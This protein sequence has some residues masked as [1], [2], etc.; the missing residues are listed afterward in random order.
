MKFT[1]LRSLLQTKFTRRERLVLLV[2]LGIVP[3]SFA[4]LLLKYTITATTPAAIQAALAGGIIT[5]IATVSSAIYKEASSYFQQTDSNVNAKVQMIT[6]LVQKYYNPWINSAQILGK[7]LGALSTKKALENGDVESLLYHIM[8]YYGYRMKF[9]LES[10]GLILL[11][12]V[13]EQDVVNQLYH[14]TETALDWKG[15]ATHGDASYLEWLFLTY[16]SAS[17]GPGG[18]PP[19]PGSVQPAKPDDAA[20]KPATGQS[21]PYLFYQFNK[22]IQQ[23]RGNPVKDPSLADM[24]DALTS[25]CKDHPDKVGD[26][27]KALDAFATTFQQSIEKLYTAWGQ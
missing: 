18:A 8:V 16:S 23:A 17:A 26:A 5:A 13:P 22:D 2:I 4:I 21:A 11:S 25:W 7:Q 27:G 24:V 20:P 6:P 3:P 19:K 14:D 10:G 1:R 12:S 9:L 15:A